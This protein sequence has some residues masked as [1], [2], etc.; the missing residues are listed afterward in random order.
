MPPRLCDA[1]LGA[2]ALRE[3]GNMP[4]AVLSRMF[5]YTRD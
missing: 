4:L 2:M 5:G 1:W 3:R